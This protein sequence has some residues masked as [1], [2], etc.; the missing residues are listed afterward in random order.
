LPA[1]VILLP[2]AASRPRL[3]APYLVLQLGFLLSL[4]LAFGQHELVDAPNE[5]ELVR[6]VLL[7]RPLQIGVAVLMLAAAGLIIV[8]LRRG[9]A[10]LGSDDTAARASLQSRTTKEK[11]FPE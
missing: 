8:R 1:L 9:D 3:L 2:L 11:L 6:Q 7:A 4:A 5:I 10:A